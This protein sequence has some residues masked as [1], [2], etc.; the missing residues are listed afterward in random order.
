M[1]E[2]R[3]YTSGIERV[4]GLHRSWRNGG[5]GD[6]KCIWEEALAELG[7]LS[8]GWEEVCL[9]PR[10]IKVRDLRR[11]PMRERAVWM[12]YPRAGWA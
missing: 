7:S 11:G 10:K 2:G 8:G 3:V 1:E 6:L 4:E 12:W 9:Y 5:E